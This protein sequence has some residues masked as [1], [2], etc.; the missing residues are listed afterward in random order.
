MKGERELA[1]LR[2]SEVLAQL[3]AYLDGELDA[4]T[5]SK[6]EAHVDACDQCERFG[7]AFAATIQALRQRLG[8]APAAPTEVSARLRDALRRSRE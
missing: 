4:A 2:C 5:R 8:A 1:G 3:S 6:I 7:G